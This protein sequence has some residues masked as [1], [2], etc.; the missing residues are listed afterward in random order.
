MRDPQTLS[1]RPGIS[2]ARIF[3]DGAQGQVSEGHH[4]DFVLVVRAA[5]SSAVRSLMSQLLPT[6]SNVPDVT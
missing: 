2:S 4:I 6:Q 5:C 1:K 3:S